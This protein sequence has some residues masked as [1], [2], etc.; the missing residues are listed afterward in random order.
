[1][2]KIEVVA[3]VKACTALFDGHRFEMANKRKCVDWQNVSAA[4]KAASP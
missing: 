1:M 3:E 2:C 4:I